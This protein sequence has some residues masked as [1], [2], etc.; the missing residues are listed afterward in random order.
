MLP[1][2]LLACNT[3]ITPNQELGKLSTRDKINTD[4]IEGQV[5]FPKS[6]LNNNKFKLKAT[7]SDIAVDAT[8]SIITPADYVDPN[9]KPNVTIATAK[10]NS[11]GGFS[12]SYS[13][14][15][16]LKDSTG[17]PLLKDNQVYVFEAIKRIGG[18]SHSLLA[19]R[20]HVLWSRTSI[21]GI[22]NMVN[23]TSGI[24]ISKYTTAASLISNLNTSSFSSNQSINSLEKGTVNDSQGDPLYNVS[25]V[26]TITNDLL[27]KVSGMV[28]QSMTDEKD[29]IYT[30]NF[31]NNDYSYNG[32]AQTVQSDVVCG[33]VGSDINCFNPSDNK[34][35]PVLSS[36]D[37]NSATTGSL[38]TLVG[39]G[40][41]STSLGANKDQAVCAS[42][43]LTVGSST[44]VISSGFISASSDFLGDPGSLKCQ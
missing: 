30:I 17:Q 2:L 43:T 24:N 18:A 39:S 35:I 9:I 26:A 41:D 27:N 13:Q 1:L 19:L 36:I 32:S 10:T 34:S 23:L 22:K 7:Q 29:P 21:S 3:T 31:T 12:F 8:V 14:L 16:A 25:S 40:F 5:E 15:N 37:K 33:G 20:T 42:I 6:I 4:L 28:I 44:P 11:S 38:I